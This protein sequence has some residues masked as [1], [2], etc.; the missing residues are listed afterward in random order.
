M[1]WRNNNYD[2]LATPHP[3]PKVGVAT[4]NKKGVLKWDNFLNF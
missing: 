3:A 1:Y 4:A 2:A